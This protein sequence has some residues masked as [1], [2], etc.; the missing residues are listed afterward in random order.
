MHMYKDELALNNLP[1][2]ICHKTKPNQIYL[3]YMYREYSVLN[4][5]QCLI[6]HKTKTNQSL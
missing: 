4:N 2:L 1:R 5:L 3:V 6:Y